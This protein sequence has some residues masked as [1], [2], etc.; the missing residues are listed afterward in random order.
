MAINDGVLDDLENNGVVD[1]DLVLAPGDNAVPSN[2]AVVTVNTD[3]SKQDS[4]ILSDES[5][6]K[7]LNSVVTFKLV[8]DGHTKLINLKDVENNILGQEAMDQKAAAYI[9]NSFGNFV[10]ESFPIQMFSEKPTGINFSKACKFMKTRIAQEEAEVVSNYELLLNNFQDVVEVVEKSMSSL[11][12]L[13]D[14][15]ETVRYENTDLL[16]LLKENKNLVVP[17]ENKFIN[18]VNEPIGSF[19]FKLIQLPN[20]DSGLIA[21]YLE[22]IKSILDQCLQLRTHILEKIQRPSS[23]EAPVAIIDLVEYYSHDRWEQFENLEEDFKKHIERLKEI[24]EIGAG[25]IR[26]VEKQLTE[27]AGEIT[28]INNFLFNSLTETNQIMLLTTTVKSLFK[29]LKKL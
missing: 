16:Q 25:D 28:R 24:K 15:L 3:T 4:S 7:L 29:E 20:V 2:A 12:V 22:S 17:Y 14:L 26:I 21:S 5:K 9:E 1:N 6:D 27:N 19:D 11:E 8:E 13:K 18:I 23:P 10:T